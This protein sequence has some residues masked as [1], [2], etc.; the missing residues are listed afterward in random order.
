MNTTFR[1]QCYDGAVKRE[2]YLRLSSTPQRALQ[3]LPQDSK[4]LKSA[5]ENLRDSLREFD[6]TVMHNAGFE[7]GVV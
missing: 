4:A 1:R 2:A 3:Q 6:V 7:N 5:S